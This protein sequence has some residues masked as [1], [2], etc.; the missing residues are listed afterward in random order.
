MDFPLLRR[1]QLLPECVKTV[2]RIGTHQPVHRPVDGVALAFPPRADTTG[3]FMHLK[4]GRFIAVH[5]PVASCRQ[6]G[7]PSPDNDY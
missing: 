1:P 3:Y 4:Y 6:A 5:S 7:E 2:L